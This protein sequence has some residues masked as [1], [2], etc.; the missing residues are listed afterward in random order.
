MKEQTLLENGR[1]GRAR[2]DAEDIVLLGMGKP[3]IAVL[4]S[5]EDILF[6]RQV[7]HEVKNL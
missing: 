3:E 1:H 4:D 6:N 7:A 2:R 5:A